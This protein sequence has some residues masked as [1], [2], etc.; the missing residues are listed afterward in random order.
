MEIAMNFKFFIPL[1]LSF[2]IASAMENGALV[3][4]PK[5]H[6]AKHDY[7]TIKGLAKGSLGAMAIWKGVDLLNVTSH[8]VGHAV[9]AK[10]FDKCP[11]NIII[12]HHLK[13]IIIQEKTFH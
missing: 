2:H 10:I 1:L 11:I 6:L 4:T 8:E 3:I 7:E 13:P 5:T 9:T 12:G